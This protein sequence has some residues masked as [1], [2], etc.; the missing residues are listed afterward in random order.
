MTNTIHWKKVVGV[1]SLLTLLSLDCPCGS[2]SVRCRRRTS[3]EGTACRRSITLA[4]FAGALF[5]RA[6]DSEPS[7]TN[8]CF[9]PRLFKGG[10]LKRAVSWKRGGR[11]LTR[12]W[13]G[14][15]F[16]LI[17]GHAWQLSI[18]AADLWEWRFCEFR[19]CGHLWLNLTRWLFGTPALSDVLP[20]CVTLGERQGRSMLCRWR[21]YVDGWTLSFRCVMLWRRWERWKAQWRLDGAQENPLLNFPCVNVRTHSTMTG[22]RIY[23]A[24]P[25]D[26]IKTQLSNS[27]WKT[28]FI[29]SA[30]SEFT[31]SYND[32]QVM[33]ISS[34][35]LSFCSTYWS[36]II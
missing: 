12:F 3:P 28:T 34:N 16:T 23:L 25:S 22:T 21:S 6:F 9:R 7:F 15:A 27:S 13:Y 19:I 8:V 31:E 26:N 1:P 4:A 24:H 33:V 17:F 35:L 14:A 32:T 29:E 30:K 11:L 20:L 10:T 2:R 18:L 36:Y 5:S